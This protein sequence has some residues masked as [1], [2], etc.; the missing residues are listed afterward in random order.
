MS[1]PKRLRGAGAAEWLLLTDGALG[2]D[3]LNKLYQR[4][5][6]PRAPSAHRLERAQVV[7]AVIGHA[8][9][10]AERGHFD[11]LNEVSQRL[12][13]RSRTESSLLAQLELDDA[14]ERLTTYGGM[15]F[16]KQRARMLWAALCAEPEA[17]NDAGMRVLKTLLDAAH[18]GQDKV[19]LPAPKSGASRSL[20]SGASRP[21][22]SAELGKLRH[23]LKRKTAQIETLR[24]T[25]E[26]LQAERASERGAERRAHEAIDQQRDQQA[27]E[28]AQIQQLKTQLKALRETHEQAMARIGALEEQLTQEQARR[29]QA[30]SDHEKALEAQRMEGLEAQ[31]DWQ[32]ERAALLKRDETATQGVVVLFDA[33]NLGAGARR[34]G[35]NLNFPALLERLLEG[36]SLR[37]AVA[38]AVAPEGAERERFARSLRNA[39]IEVRWKAKQTFADGTTKADWDVGLAV[40][41]M[42]WAGRAATVIIASGDGDF[43]PLIPALKALGTEVEVAGWPGRLNQTLADRAARLITLDQHDVIAP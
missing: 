10:Q 15:R 8:L 13:K 39:S 25:I 3:D 17:L 32:R 31:R 6:P 23:N 20:P 38:F 37:R 9:A 21:Q 33:A 11:A 29:A 40:T 4:H 18:S 27:S 43:L 35:G 19:E 24:Q 28:R 41:A 2:R 1:A 5:A 14:L 22:D 7:G 42:Q 26:T 12:S 16:K 34:F 36:R 30:A